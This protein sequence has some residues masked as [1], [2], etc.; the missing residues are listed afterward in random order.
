MLIIKPNTA[1]LGYIE[2]NG[3]S[4]WFFLAILRFVNW[5]KP[6]IPRLWK[7]QYS[8]LPDW[9]MSDPF[10]AKRDWMPDLHAVPPFLGSGLLQTRYF[11]VPQAVSFSFVQLLLMPYC[12][13]DHPPFTVRDNLVSVCCWHLC[14][15][16]QIVWYCWKYD[17][18]CEY[19]ER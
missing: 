2:L 1:K 13:P 12:Q 10:S 16:I 9:H 8:Y 6:L 5:S 18:N 19:R 4:S 17:Q 15:Q 14:K 7:L 11:N 3:I